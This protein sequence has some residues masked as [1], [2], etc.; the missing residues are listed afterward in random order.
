MEKNP[1]YH[2]GDLRRALMAAAVEVIEDVGPAA[3]SLRAVARRA[4]VTH[5]AATYHF[6]D[7][8]GLLTAVATE[9]YVLL[10]DTLERV[11]SDGG[12]FLDIGVAYVHFAVTQRAHFE[13]MYRPELYDQADESLLRARSVAATVLY[14]TDSPTVEETREGV[15][16][17]AIVHGIATLWLNGALPRQLGSD[18]EELTR[19]VASYLNVGRT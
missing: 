3:M 16:A 6:G 13:V 9:G 7:K 15:A 2:H 17:W 4:G 11:R 8:A 1:S 5:P 19:T 18:P 14:G 10:G 12:T